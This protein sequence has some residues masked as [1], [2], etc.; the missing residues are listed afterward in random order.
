MV[1]VQQLQQL[2]CPHT[3]ADVDLNTHTQPDNSC[4]SHTSLVLRTLM[5]RGREAR[6]ISL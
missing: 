6:V 4:S 5:D 2:C 1:S 3:Q